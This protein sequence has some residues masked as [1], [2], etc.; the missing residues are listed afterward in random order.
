MQ[1][2]AGMAPTHVRSG[3]LERVGVGVTAAGRQRVAVLLKHLEQV[4]CPLSCK[5]RHTL[6]VGC[7]AC[8]QDHAGRLNQVADEVSVL[9][10]RQVE[11]RLVVL[12]GQYVVEKP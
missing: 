4:G 6:P 11:P 12:I 9:S 10:V 7:I 5:R 1:K 8:V 2:P 3:H